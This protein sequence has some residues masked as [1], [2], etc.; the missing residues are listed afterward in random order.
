MQLFRSL[1]SRSH[2][3]H[4]RTNKYVQVQNFFF[5]LQSHDIPIKFIL[6]VRYSSTVVLANIHQPSP[7]QTPALFKAQTPNICDLQ[8]LKETN[9]E[10]VILTFVTALMAI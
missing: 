5:F 8:C 3:N 4:I 1:T 10:M 7:V 2:T 9:G 6:M